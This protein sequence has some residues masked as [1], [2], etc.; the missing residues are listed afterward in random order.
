MKHEVTTQATAPIAEAGALVNADQIIGKTFGFWTVL[1]FSHVHPNDKYK[2]FYLVKCVC[3]AEKALRR[4]SLERGGTNSCGCER[5]KKFRELYTKHGQSKGRG[6]AYGIWCGM[7]D[8]CNRPASYGYKWYGAKGVKVCERWNSDYIAFVGDV[9]ER[10]GRLTIDRIKTDGHY[11][12]GKCDQCRANGWP[13]NVRWATYVEQAN[14]RP[15]NI[16]LELNG[17]KRSV[18]EWSLRI[19]VPS[20]ALRQRFKAGWTPQ[21]IL[22]TPVQV[23]GFKKKVGRIKRGKVFSV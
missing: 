5:D 15:D 14:N 19:G 3:G 4:D 21:E 7:K 22:T 1:R 11:S 12:C 17:E 16:R 6:G 8:R 9:G 20:E 13:M 10:V 23:R 18:E 2:R